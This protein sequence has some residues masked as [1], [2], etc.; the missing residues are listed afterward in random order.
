MSS[1]KDTNELSK[2]L[3]LVARDIGVK[4][5]LGRGLKR[6]WGQSHWPFRHLN[7]QIRKGESL[8]ILGRNGSGKSTLLR[9][10]A[11]I[12]SVDEGTI[13]RQEGMKSIILAPGVGFDKLNTGRENLINS[14]IYQGFSHKDIAEKLDAIIDYSELGNWID[15]PVSTYSAGMKARLGF[16]LSIHVPSDILLI[17]ESLSAGDASFRDKASAAVK[18]L[19]KSDKTVLLISHNKNMLKEM[20]E[21]G[22]LINKGEQIGFGP[23]EDMLA[24]YEE[25]D[26]ASLSIKSRSQSIYKNGD[27]P[28]SGLDSDIDSQVKSL[29]TELN[30][31]QE[32]LKKIKGDRQLIQDKFWKSSD[33]LVN[34]ISKLRAS[35]RDKQSEEFDEIL[36]GVIEKSNLYSS[37]K[38]K[39]EE[40]REEFW[41]I[42]RKIDKT[43]EQLSS[44]NIFLA[45]CT[46]KRTQKLATP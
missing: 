36:S 8:A 28:L 33:D 10:I 1:Q 6:L 9:A 11:D 13:T 20:C 18:H 12:I 14:A 27:E 15:Q 5:P 45:S 39:N 19:I 32:I 26:Q 25:L 24:K 29:K 3:C 46:C 16:S 42:R 17:D 44:I 34:E 21:N 40:L 35:A 38:D 2:D 41:D 43:R 22:L 7:F 30:H 31:Q 37:M 4:L 23:I